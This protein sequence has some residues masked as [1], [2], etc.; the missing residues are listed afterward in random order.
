VPFITL[1][2][3]QPGRMD[4]RTRMRLEAFVSMLR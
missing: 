4:A 1:E 3:D 2:G